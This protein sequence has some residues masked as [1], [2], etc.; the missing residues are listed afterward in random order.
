[1]TTRTPTSIDTANTADTR[2]RRTLGPLRIAILGII[3]LG[4]VGLATELG[5]LEHYEEAW[6]TAPLILLGAATIA[7]VVHLAWDRGARSLLALRIVGALVTMAGPI[8]LFLH[9]RANTEFEQELSPDLKG[10][11]LFWEAI[12]GVSP[13]S[14]AP[15][16][17]MQLGL[18]MLAYTL[19]HPWAR[20][21]GR[22]AVG[23]SAAASASSA[24][25]TTGGHE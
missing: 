5:L 1:M 24:T 23:S 13:P 15:G 25:A 8:G 10:F 2:A 4:I 20:S 18:L 9:Y 12:H 22:D 17:M 19:R 6:Q 16:A 7:I 3:G 21:T 11:E 14:L